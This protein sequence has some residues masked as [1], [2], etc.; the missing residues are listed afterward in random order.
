[1]L[2]ITSMLT[3]R[4]HPMAGVRTAMDPRVVLRAT[5]ATL[6]SVLLLAAGFGGYDAALTLEPS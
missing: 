3:A 5:P 2:A 6:E 1:M 4:V